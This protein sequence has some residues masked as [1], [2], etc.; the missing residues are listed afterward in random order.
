VAVALVLLAVVVVVG[1]FSTSEDSSSDDPDAGQQGL[2]VG[3]PAQPMSGWELM[4]FPGAGTFVDVM[5]HPDATV[6]LART[7]TDLI[8]ILGLPNL[9]DPGLAASTSGSAVWVLDAV[10]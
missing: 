8:R 3:G 7:G 5:D 1:A 6:A 10:D 2:V 9:D 4:Y